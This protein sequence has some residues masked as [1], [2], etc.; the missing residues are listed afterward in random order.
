MSGRPGRSFRCNL[1]RKPS[2]CNNFRTVNSG[3]VSVERILRMFSLRFKG[4]MSVDLRTPFCGT[5]PRSGIVCSGEMNEV[6]FAY[7]PLASSLDGR[8]A[9]LP[10][11]PS[12][13][14]GVNV[15]VLSSLRYSQL[16]W[17]YHVTTR[18]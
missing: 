17:Y 12:D 9:F 6:S 4:L 11:V 14:F 1:K 13:S 15:Q 8:E 18:C 16:F 3:P 2:S 7:E 5:S 10:Y